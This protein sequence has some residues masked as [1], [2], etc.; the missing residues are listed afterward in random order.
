MAYIND[1]LSLRDFNKIAA[2]V[3]ECS[4]VHLSD[5]KRVMIESRLKKRLNVL[6]ILSFKK[7]IDYLHSSEGLKLELDHFIHA[8]TTHKTDFFRE[9]KH[10][11][12]LY[13]SILPELLK[14]K[15]SHSPKSIRIW[16]AACSRGDEPYTLAMVVNEFQENCGIDFNYTILASDIS[17]TVVEHAKLAIYPQESIEPVP[18]DYKQK[19]LL[20]SKDPAKDAYRIHPVLRKNTQL[21]TQ[22]L[23]DI[24]FALKGKVDVVFLRNVVIYFNDEKQLEIINRICSYIHKGG[25]LIMGHSEVLTVAD[26][27]VRAVAP[28][29]YQVL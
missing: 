10:F 25:Y 19:Y 9:S 29:V 26:Y 23:T 24:Q 21:F 5:K 15:S 13:E 22:N 6:Q 27:P 8:I 18:E 11:D 14:K 2:F 12:Y 7:Y 3:Y 4:G 1:T 16:S 20:R 17:K 28:T